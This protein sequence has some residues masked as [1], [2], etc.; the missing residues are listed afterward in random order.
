MLDQFSK[1]E[2]ARKVENKYPEVPELLTNPN[3]QDDE[4][5]VIRA[6]GGSGTS[7][8]KFL[9]YQVRST[10]RSSPLPQV[11][12]YKMKN[13][14]GCFWSSFKQKRAD[15]VFVDSSKS[16]KLPFIQAKTTAD[17][18]LHPTG[19]RQRLRSEGKTL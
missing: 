17:G 14:R 5:F 16:L 7:R 15:W 12:N 4:E 13:G 11:R 18:I 2:A 1:G 8:E 6:K 10:R 3:T 9:L 19:K